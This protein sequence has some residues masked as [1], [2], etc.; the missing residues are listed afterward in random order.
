MGA[1]ITAYNRLDSAPILVHSN[2]YNPNIVV[3]V[4][5][6]LIGPV[7]VTAGIR[8]VAPIIVNSTRTPRR[9]DRIWPAAAPTCM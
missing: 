3:V 8:K 1:P 6:T 9:S 4:D 2:I 5:E 7:D